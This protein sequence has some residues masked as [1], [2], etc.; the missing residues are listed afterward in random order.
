MNRLEDIEI[1]LPHQVDALTRYVFH[2]YSWL[3]TPDEGRAFGWL[4]FKGKMQGISGPMRSYYEGKQ[5]PLDSEAKR[6]LEAGAREFLITTRDRILRD[7]PDEVYLNRCPKCDALTR[8][9]KACLCP[10]CNHTWFE[11]RRS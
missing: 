2:N 10:V 1:V 8:T 4:L 7:H 3:M 11:T 5:G 6:L 9:P